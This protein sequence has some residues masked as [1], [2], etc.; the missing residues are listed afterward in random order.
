MRALISRITLVLGGLV[1]ALAAGE[2]VL[3]VGGVEPADLMV[4]DAV[5]GQ[6]YRPNLR[7]SLYDEESRRSVAVSVNSHGFRD[8][9]HASPSSPGRVVMLGDSFA[10]GLSVDFDR[11]FPQICKRLLNEGGGDWDV[12]SLAVAGFGTAQE[13]L[14][15]EQFGRAFEPQVVVL[16]FFAGNDISDNSPELSTALRPYFVVRDGRLVATPAS[17][18][19]RA[20]TGWLN[21]HSRLYTWQKR[22]TQKIE[23]VVKKDVVIDPVLRVFLSQT[24]AAMERAWGVTEALILR[25]RGE[26]EAGGGRLLVSYI[27]FAD[28]V[29][30]DWWD[31]TI[32][33]SRPLADAQ[34]SLD[35]PSTRLAE[36]CR[37]NGIAFVSVRDAFRHEDGEERLYFPHGHFN[38]RGHRAYAARLVSEIRTIARR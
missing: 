27:P 7:K 37:R 12:M 23:R 24:D 21:E 3:R 32:R 15:F 16:N 17:E 30:A 35:R 1:V 33:R 36:F 4:R 14:A 25:L 6:T 38:E 26:V 10:A 28:E 20:L 11:T 18:S 22:Q 9:E 19:R 13:L 8:V 31:E 29:N 34:W 5:L 2:A